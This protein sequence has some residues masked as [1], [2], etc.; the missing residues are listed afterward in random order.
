VTSRNGEDLRP[1]IFTLAHERGW[2]LRE[3]TRD[4]HSLEDIYMQVTRPDEEEES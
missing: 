1:R 4:R 2:I 3:L